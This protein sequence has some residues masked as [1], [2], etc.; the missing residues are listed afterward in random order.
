MGI[1]YSRKTK[2]CRDAKRK[3]TIRLSLITAMNPG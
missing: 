3:V 1:I 2:P